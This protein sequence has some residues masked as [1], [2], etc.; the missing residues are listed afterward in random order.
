[1]TAAFD[2]NQRPLPPLILP[3]HPPFS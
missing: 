3:L 1:M 2:F